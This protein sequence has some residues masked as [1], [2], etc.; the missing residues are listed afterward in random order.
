MEQMKRSVVFLMGIAFLSMVVFSCKGGSGSGKAA[1]SAYVNTG[2]YSFSGG[3]IS[4]EVLD[5]YLSRAITEAEYLCSEGMNNDGDFGRED[6]T[7][8]LLD[9]GAKF[10]GRSIYVWGHESLFN[11]PR[12]LANAKEKV[13]AY[14]AKDPDAIFQAAMFEAVYKSQ[15][16]QVRIPEWVFNAFNL[17]P[18]NRNFNY[19]SMCF[20]DGSYRNQ[21]GR[22]ASVP[23]MT[24]QETQLW[25]YFMGIKYM[26][27]GI[28]AFHLGQIDLICKNEKGDYSSMKKVQAMLREAART[29]A[30]R[31][32]ILFDAHSTQGGTAVGNELLLDFTSFPL[33]LKELPDQPLKVVLEAGYLDSIISRTKGGVTPSGWECDHLPYI[34]EFDNFGKTKHPGIP[35]VNDYTAW[36]YDEISWISH[37]GQDYQNEFFEYAVKFLYETDPNGFIQMPGMRVS[38]DGK[39]RWYRLNRRSPACPDGHNGEKT[40]RKLWSN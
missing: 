14:H 23:D 30:R 32:T 39:E 17:Y 13:D 8:M 26:E 5:N 16:E 36:G 34:L 33:R 38:A 15:I 10:I 11:N 9:I 7:R 18:E 1:P 22:D 29:K 4:R 31:G 21:W 25:F 28:E 12:W 24:R 3:K 35:D 2:N 6:D 27:A 20:P 37:C 19:E 40:V